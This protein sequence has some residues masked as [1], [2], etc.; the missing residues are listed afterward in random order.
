MSKTLSV[1]VQKDY[2]ES[3][4]N[5][6][7]ASGLMELIWNALDADS[8]EIEIVSVSDSLGYQ[9]IEVRDNGHGMTHEK[10][11][12][13]FENLGG[14]T[15]KER[16]FSPEKRA[17]HGEEGKGRY[18][19][20]G[21]GHLITFKSYYIDKKGDH[22]TFNVTLDR[23]KLKSPDVSEPLKRKKDGKSGVTVSIDN[24]EQAKINKVFSESSIQNIEQKLAIYYQQYPNFTIKINGKNL[25]FSAHIL[26]EI[27]EPIEF[28]LEENSKVTYKFELRVVEW[29]RPCDKKLYY[30]SKNG[31]SFGETGLGVRTSGVKVSAYLM[32]DYI[33]EL[34]RKNQLNI[35]ELDIV[36]SCAYEEAKGIIRKYIRERIHERGAEFIKELKDKA[37]YPYKDEPSGEVEIA[38]RQVFD[39]VALNI[40]EYVPNFSQQED[41]SQKLTL[42]L[43]KEALESDSTAFQKIITEVINLP[44]DKIQDLKEL[45]ETTSLSDVIDTMKEVTDRL[46][47]LY[48]LKIVVMDTKQNK[49]VL[50]RKH[51]H[52]IIEHETWIFGDEYTLGASDVNL[53][54]VLST[55]LKQLGRENLESIVEEGDNEELTTIPDVCLYKQ[56]NNGKH[57]YFRNLVIE[58][59]RPTCKAGTDEYNQI[60]GYASKVSAD[61]RFEKDKT[62]WTFILLVNEIKDE[63]RLQCEQQHR[64]FGHVHASDNLNVHIK[65]WGSIFNEAEARHQY[66]KEKLNYSISEDKEGL[67]L[68]SKKYN[69]YLPKELA[70]KINSN[71]K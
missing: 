2:L 64:E 29:S 71:P 57:G 15:K 8:S 39:I 69:E 10:A 7:G 14:S 36:M 63:I 47:L 65:T 41:V 6:S 48:E 3:L 24:L 62:E 27:N 23:N 13:A 70:K 31:I 17:Y 66:L 4:T 1:N 28:K 5:V 35:A 38:T 26:N 54:N 50:E 16:K 34:H 58:L 67:E 12:S 19:A 53:K 25:D 46:R 18:N 21:L 59:K 60:M 32:S 9:S 43:V 44:E 68:L 40:N 20:F 45:L 49:K 42:S 52:K 51:L 11:L 61:N 56:H 33:D 22:F 55:H 37:L 30:C